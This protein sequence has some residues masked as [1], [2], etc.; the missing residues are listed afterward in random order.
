ML[1][2]ISCSKKAEAYIAR[3]LAMFH[4][5]LFDD[6]DLQ[7]KTAAN[8]DGC[9]LGYYPV[10]AVDRGR[11]PHLVSFCGLLRCRKQLARE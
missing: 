1:L 5:F 7:F 10:L 11:T 2:Q 9:C 6:A 3:G 8:T 4:F